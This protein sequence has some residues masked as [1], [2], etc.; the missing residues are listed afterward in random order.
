MYESQ[1]VLKFCFSDFKM[2]YGVNMLLLIGV[3]DCGGTL[4][5]M[6]LWMRK[7]SFGGVAVF[8]VR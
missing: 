8:D 6:P 7:S 2:T 3:L 5:L 1:L 4:F